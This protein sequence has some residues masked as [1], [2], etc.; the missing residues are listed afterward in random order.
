MSCWKKYLACRR[1]NKKRGREN[2]T[3]VKPNPNGFGGKTAGEAPEPEPPDWNERTGDHLVLA[4]PAGA[5]DPVEELAAG[6]VLHDDGEVRG[7]E[8]DLEK[9]GGP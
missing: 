7:R 6:G 2:S 3:S 9:E 8:H 5:A 4:E 1:I